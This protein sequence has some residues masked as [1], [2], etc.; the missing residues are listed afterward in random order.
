MT[1]P[2]YD[3]VIIGAGI[4]GIGAACHLRTNRPET[5]FAILESRD[6][7]GGTWSLFRYPGLRSD[8]DMATFGFG[9]KPWT[10]RQAIAD[11]EHILAYLEETVAEYDLD[12]QI[13]YGHRVVAADFSRESGLWTLTITQNGLPAA[14]ITA[15]HLFV[16]TGYY[17]YDEGHTPAIAG[18]EKFS[19]ELIHPQHW[20]ETFDSTGKK[21]VVIG[22]GA[23]AVTLIPALAKTADHVTMLQ[24]SPSYIVSLPKEDPIS[25]GIHKIFRPDLAHAIVR[26]KNI[27]Q[28]RAIYKLCMRF[29]RLMRRLLVTQVRLQLARGYDV[30]THF[31]PRYK[32]WDQR[33]CAVPDGDLFKTLKSAK[34]SVVT[35]QI[36]HVTAD[37]IQLQSGLYLDADVIV[38]ATGLNMQALGQIQFSVDG[39][40]VSL[41]STVAFKAMMV[42]GLPNLVF[43]VGYTN[44]SHTLRVDLIAEHFVRTLDYM[45]EH[46]YTT[47]E[48]VLPAE[49]MELLPLYQLAAGY[50]QRGISQFPRAGTRGSWTA[51]GAYEEDVKRLRRGPVTDDDLVFGRAQMPA[52]AITTYTQRG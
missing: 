39:E 32:P 38:T 11:A 15:R 36:D 35:D 33:L 22:S 45:D 50:V 2:G 5:T 28:T 46:G 49:P 12:K 10:H 52:A 40:P 25:N 13:R 16:G 43:I 3:V 6:S 42:S 18:L 44:I 37:G 30:K 23:T 17:D 47:F 20:P 14:P 24:R 27:F 26:R 7:F 19:G 34:A 8:S 51:A 9:F 29:P 4:S 41:P 1:K 31:T 21:V 48:P